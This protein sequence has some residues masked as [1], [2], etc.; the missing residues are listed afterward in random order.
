MAL[1]EYLCE[2]CQ[3]RFE[4]LTSGME[5][6]PGHCPKCKSAQ[7]RRLISVFRVGGRGDLRESTFHGCHDHDLASAD[8]NHRDAHD[9]GDSGNSDSEAS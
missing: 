1:H 8:H 6:N 3:H 7:T 4:H 5:P 9:H 2:S